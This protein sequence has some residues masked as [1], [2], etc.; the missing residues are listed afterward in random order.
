M[1]AIETRFWPVL[2]AT[3]LNIFINQLFEPVHNP[4]IQAVTFFGCALV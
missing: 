1:E 4:Y 2:Y 3:P